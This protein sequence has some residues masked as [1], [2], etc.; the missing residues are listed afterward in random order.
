VN[1]VTAMQS[2]LDQRKRLCTLSESLNGADVIE[3]SE[4]DGTG[5]LF[6]GAAAGSGRMW[7][8]TIGECSPGSVQTAPVGGG[9]GGS[10]GLGLLA[11]SICTP[12][13]AAAAVVRCCGNR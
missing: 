4:C 13:T 6:S 5:G 11:S 10:A 9:G 1:F 8:T 12:M 3:A 7:T 2:C